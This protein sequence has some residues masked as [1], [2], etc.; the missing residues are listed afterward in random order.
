MK[1]R[2]SVAEMGRHAYGLGPAYDVINALEKNGVKATLTLCG[3]KSDVFIGLDTDAGKKDTDFFIKSGDAKEIKQ[4]LIDCGY[5]VN[6]KIKNNGDCWGIEVYTGVPDDGKRDYGQ[7]IT[8]RKMKKRTMALEMFTTFDDVF[9]GKYVEPD[10]GDVFW[11]GDNVKVYVNSKENRFLN[12]LTTKKSNDPRYAIYFEDITKR[13]GEAEAR[14]LAD[15]HG[16]GNVFRYKDGEKLLRKLYSIV[17]GM[18]DH[19]EN[20]RSDLECNDC[21][22]Q[23]EGL[24]KTSGL[25]QWEVN[26]YKW[27]W[28][29]GSGEMPP[30]PEELAALA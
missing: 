18:V 17:N 5:E 11:E 4:T 27:V 26:F 21:R 24:F 8:K 28:G 7:V 2:Y 13:F 10:C 30:L 3:S 23:Q 1:P 25:E 16:F 29:N 15:E 14:Q 6:D 22:T 19:C 20:S 12:I 9:Y